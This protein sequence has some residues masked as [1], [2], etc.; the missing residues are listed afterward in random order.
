MGSRGPIVL[1]KNGGIQ[2]NF[3][4]MISHISIEGEMLAHF[5]S[6]FFCSNAIF[7]LGS[8]GPT[9]L[10]NFGGSVQL[11]KSDFTRRSFFGS[12]DFRKQRLHMGK[13]CPKLNSHSSAHFPR[14]IL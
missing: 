11:W 12:I 10:E 13:C 9:V 2:C 6:E 14:L 7:L 8:R 5:S 3:E 4:N 1:E